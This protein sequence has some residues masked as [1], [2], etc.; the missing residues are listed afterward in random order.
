MHHPD[1]TSFQLATVS[2]EA[3]AEIAIWKPRMEQL[4]AI[5]RG[6]RV[7]A[8]KEYAKL[9]G[10]GA[11]TLLTMYGRWKKQGDAA[12][13]DQR[14]HGRDLGNVK[15][16]GLPVAF[17]KFWQGEFLRQ[18]RDRTLY[19]AWEQLIL[20]L[21]RWRRGDASA[22]IPGYDRPP[23]NQRGT[24]HPAGWGY[25][26]LTR[27]KPD[28]LTQRFVRQGRSSAKK[29]MHMVYHTR[30]GLRVGQVYIMDDQEHDVEVTYGNVLCRPLSFNIL[31]L[32]SGAD[33]AQGYQP[34]KDASGNNIGLKEEQAWWL[35]LHVLTAHGYRDDGTDIIVERGT[36]TLRDELAQGLFH[37]TRGRVR[38]RK[39]GVDNAAL[40][41]FLIAGRSK[42]NPNWKAARESWFNLLRNR[43]ALLEGPTG[44]DREHAPEELDRKRRLVEKMLLTVPENRR[45]LLS[46]K[47]LFL[48][49]EQFMQM[50][51]T[52]ELGIIGAIN[53]RIDHDL[54]GWESCGFTC[55]EY[56]VA[57]LLG[58]GEGYERWANVERLQQH[59]LTL[60]EDR[61][62]VL[63]AA[64][65]ADAQDLVRR[66][67]LSPLEV[68]HQGRTELTKLS[69]WTWNVV[70]PVRMARKMTARPNREFHIDDRSLSSDRLIYPAR[71]FNAD[72][73]EVI[74]R[75]GD[76][77]L[78]YVNPFDT[79]EV[80]CCGTNG[81]AIGILHQI[82]KG[83]QYGEDP[84]T[85]QNLGRARQMN[86]DLEA[87]IAHTV[88]AQAEE[89]TA[90]MEH[91]ARVMSGQPITPEEKQAART[92]TALTKAADRILT[93]KAPAPQ[94][95]TAH[96]PA[97]ED[98]DHL[99]WL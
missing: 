70:M 42:G 22:A 57:A 66:R 64:I 58:M 83:H 16:K 23:H 60:P 33:I 92:S 21:N 62:E 77:V 73:R 11:S 87:S 63:A 78:L 86:A 97:E 46:L 84:I 13:L 31:D 26:N 59:M 67:K 1:L 37:A 95:S 99:S 89:R 53:S 80:L 69:P 38:V 96:T 75:A 18:H 29:L 90:V 41:G 55:T 17:I 48:T 88:T 36:A 52:T 27:Q 49:S 43:M 76:E 93:P 50:I 4:D 82:I 12:L 72:N 24:R 6:G 56:N 65:H 61:Q 44:K 74:M 71:C 54:E 7:K 81:K 25:A 3:R 51:G 45:E 39:G 10:K 5:G 14:T 79:R 19:A 91:N 28:E 94:L 15:A 40:K 20:R 85:L 47:T 9:W 32:L 34:S 30:V 35:M 98:D 2:A 8:A 68:W